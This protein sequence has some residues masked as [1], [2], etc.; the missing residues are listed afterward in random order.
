[1]RRTKEQAE[2]TRIAI[3]AAAERLFLDKGVAHSSLE[4]IARDAGVTRGAVYWHFEN[5]AHL[6]NDMLNQVRLPPEQ[7]SMRLSGC[8][9]VDPLLSLRELS[10]EAIENLGRDEQKRRIF[11]ILLHRCEFT[12]ELREAEIRH[13]AFI[14]KFIDLVETLF[15]RDD[16]RPRLQPGVTPRLAA[17]ALHAQIIGLFTDWTRDPTL[18]DPL[19]DTAGLIDALLRGLLRDWNP[20]A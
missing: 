5:K 7:M 11:T 8:D 16:C 9:G 13:N 19:R 20:P 14:N 12:D 15:A 3:L 4:Q 10:I 18:F 2:L 6:F 1:M 17:R